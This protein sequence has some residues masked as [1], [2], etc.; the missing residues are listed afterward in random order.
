M[1]GA[2]ISLTRIDGYVTEIEY[3]YWFYRELGP[4]ALNLVLTMQGVEPVPLAEGFSYCELGCGH[5]LSVNIFSACHPNGEFHGVDFN[6]NHIVN[7]REL[8]DQAKRSNAFFWEA[9]FADLDKLPLPDFDFIVLHGVYSWINAENR[10]HILEFIRR[11]LKKGGVVYV[12]YNTMPGWA[13]FMPVRELLISYADA[14]PGPIQEQIDR[15]VGFLAR[16]NELNVSYFNNNPSAKSL[17]TS[18]SACPSSYLAH[19]LFNRDWKLFYHSDV[20]QELISAGIFFAGSA[21][22]IDNIDSLRFSPDEARLFNEIAD[23]VMRES[24]KDLMDCQQFRRDVFTKG[25]P[26]LPAEAHREGFCKIRFAALLPESAGELTAKFPRGE[27]K[28]SEELYRPVLSAL[29]EGPHSVEGMLLRKDTGQLGRDK[30]IEVLMVLA[31]AGRIVPAVEPPAESIDSARLLNYAIMEYAVKTG[32]DIPFLA[33]PVLQS[34][35][36]SDWVTR[37][38]LVCEITD[39]GDLLS[40]AQTVM[41]RGRYPLLKDGVALQS[42]DE[43]AEELE[44]RVRAFPTQELPWL[45]QLRVV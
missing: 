43:I 6:H 9:S 14:E 30:L 17:L 24:V 31:A 37:A 33:S 40:F 5:G 13:S 18:L 35:L 10:Q 2:G 29:K 1:R 41:Q 11:K 44:R 45:K 39:G 26:S 32:L 21:N 23:P 12:S 42:T 28:L 16:L 8:S 34:A 27:A 4:S 38:L 3:V 15:S 7:A 22:L 25:R 19:E 20:A 36:K